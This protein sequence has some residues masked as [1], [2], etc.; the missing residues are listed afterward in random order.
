MKFLK[1]INA[2]LFA[3]AVIMGCL[4]FPEFKDAVVV[5]LKAILLFLE[6]KKKFEDEAVVIAIL[7]EIL[8]AF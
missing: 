8:E 4:A 2:F 1:K 7:I 6:N 5:A 3:I